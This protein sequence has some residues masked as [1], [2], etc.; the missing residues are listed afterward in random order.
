MA[1]F[2]VII[3]ICKT[4]AKRLPVHIV[5]Y[6]HIVC[7]Y[8]YSISYKLS[9][10]QHIVCIYSFMIP[11]IPKYLDKGLYISITK[12]MNLRNVNNK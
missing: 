1:V 6:I 11:R 4:R 7:M 9:Y 3:N 5:S 12:Y 2:L 8:V 10:K